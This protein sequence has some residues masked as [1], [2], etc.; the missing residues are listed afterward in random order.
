MDIVIM[1]TGYVGLV[2]GVCFA[3]MGHF[4][5][6]LDIDEEKIKGLNN[7]IIPFYEPGLQELIDRNY[8]EKRLTFTTSQTP[9][10]RARVIFI[11]VG[12]PSDE[13]GR[14][15]LSHV[16][17]AARSIGDSL[18]H[19]TVIVNKSTVPMGTTRLLKKII[20]EELSRRKVSP[21]FDIIACPEFLKEG[22]AI[23]DCM[24]PDRIVIGSDSEQ[25]AAL[26][27]QL[28]LPFTLN[29]NRIL[30]MDIESAELTK[31]ASNAMLA[32]R[33]SFM[34][35]LSALCEKGGANIHQV[36]QGMSA[37]QRI[38]YHFLYA[39]IGYGG[40]C[41]PKD[42]RALCSLAQEWKCQTPLLHAVDQANQNQKN[43][44][45]NLIETYFLDK[46]SLCGKTIA[47]WGLAFKP[48]T[49]DIR[50]SP[51]LELVHFLLRK[52]ASLR[53]Y[54]PAAMDNAKKALQGKGPIQFCANEYE[55][56]HHAHAIV[57]LTEWKQFRFVDLKKILSQMH[58]KAFFDGRNQYN[59][60]EMALKGFDYTGIGVPKEPP[61]FSKKADSRDRKKELKNES[62]LDTHSS[63]IN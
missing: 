60:K 26:V 20:Q 1:G 35:E 42:L 14:A 51:A 53:L 52:K 36:R 41:F 21:S 59:P 3:E 9:L 15:D 34:N 30:M 11:A 46:G 27:K 47:V 6:C 44:F 10:K 54:D 28:Y 50:E 31:Y 56:T 37:D 19:N 38:G 32:T 7:G 17:A 22:S 24:K 12:T 58:G 25:G 18:D 63:L 13:R 29:H 57:L 23:E 45:F 61:F 40:S 8:R 43:R 2:T 33:I 55:A 39:G 48:N 62:P 16:K 5:H 4:V 49:D